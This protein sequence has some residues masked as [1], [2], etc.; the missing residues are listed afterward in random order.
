[1]TANASSKA[2]AI[3]LT[4][5]PASGKSTIA[6]ALKPKLEAA[7]HV[8]EVLESDAVRR[9]L[10]PAPTYSRE[11]RDLFYRALAFMG[12][13]LVAH[14]VTVI[15]DATAN[16]RAYRDFARTLIP[17]FIEVAVV[18]PLE[19]CMQ[20]DYKGT[21]QRGQRGETSTVP[22]LQDAYEAPAYPEVR[23]D[24]TRFSAKEAAETIFEYARNK[25]G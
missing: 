20:R 4:G 1:M 10:T 6:A 7:G 11:E 14:G 8:V 19:L 12:S 9:I 17:R 16:R 24:T 23:I 22:G 25:F 2:C 21:Y 13:R 5:L 18:C 3:W 15:F